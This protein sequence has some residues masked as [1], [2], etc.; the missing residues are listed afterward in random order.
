MVEH[1]RWALDHAWVGVALDPEWRMHPGQVPG[2]VIGHVDAAEVNRAAAYVAR[3]TH[4]NDLPQKVFVIHEFRTDMVRRIGLV[5]HR[6]SLGPAHG[7]VRDSPPEA[8]DVPRGGA[9]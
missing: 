9:Q 8:G 4:R 2:R 7:W 5:R 3:L 1:Y 6:P